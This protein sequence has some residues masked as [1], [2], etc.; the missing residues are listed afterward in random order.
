MIDAEINEIKDRVFRALGR[1]THGS[2]LAQ[3]ARE[4]A[5]T[6]QG[7]RALRA[8]KSAAPQSVKAVVESE[9]AWIK[10]QLFTALENDTLDRIVRALKREGKKGDHANQ[11]EFDRLHTYWRLLDEKRRPPTI[12]E[13][14]DKRDVPNDS[15]LSE[16]RGM[17][18]TLKRHNLPYTERRTGRPPGKK[19]TVHVQGGKLRK[20][21]NIGFVDS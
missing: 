6:R 17:R 16:E 9:E 12:L 8:N 11:L 19:S 15:R 4:I 3:M 10:N 14:A 1:A 5:K 18:V 20:R 21:G 7:L 13:I 2:S